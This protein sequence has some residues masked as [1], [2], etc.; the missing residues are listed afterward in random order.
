[1]PL[2]APA[3]AIVRPSVRTRRLLADADAMARVFAPGRV[4]ELV[5]RSGE[6]ADCYRL[7]YHVR[8]LQR[9]SREPTPREVHDVEVSLPEDYPR[10]PPVCR[11][12]TPVFHPNI[13]TS[14][15]CIGDHWTAGERLVDLCI[16]IG[17]MLAYQAYNIRSPLDAEAA[18]FADLNPDKLPTDPRDLRSLL[19]S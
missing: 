1:M 6:P 18:M 17:E 4:I 10:L 19:E 15:I 7:R 16:R 8:S 12:L 11:M 5:E 13:D 9:V 14:T 3:D 2:K